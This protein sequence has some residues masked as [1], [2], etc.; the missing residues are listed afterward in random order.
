MQGWLVGTWKGGG[1]YQLQGKSCHEKLF[2]TTE[3]CDPNL[4]GPLPV[5][6][7]GA[8][9]IKHVYPHNCTLIM[10]LSDHGASQA[11]PAWYTAKC[12]KALVKESGQSHILWCVW[13]CDLQPPGAGESLVSLKLADLR[14]VAFCTQHSIDFLRATQH[15][16]VKCDGDPAEFG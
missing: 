9:K 6:F 14:D 15:G 11:G 5:S 12:R 10:Q 3:A 4:L 16:P 7:F 13:Q 1:N 2:S 8:S